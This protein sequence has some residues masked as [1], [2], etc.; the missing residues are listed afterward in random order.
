MLT[1]GAS[2][3]RVPPTPREAWLSRH[4][5]YGTVRLQEAFARCQSRMIALCHLCAITMFL[6]QL[7]G[8][9]EEDHEQANGPTLH[10]LPGQVHCEK[11]C[12]LR[13]R[14]PDG[15]LS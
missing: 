9:L 12:I 5:G 13:H 3:D 4:P 1:A 10:G 11:S 8:R 14:A 15:F 7:E 6:R 2:A